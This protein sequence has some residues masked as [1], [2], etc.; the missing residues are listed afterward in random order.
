VWSSFRYLPPVAFHG[1]GIF[2]SEF[3]QLIKEK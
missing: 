2:T 3:Y 1:V